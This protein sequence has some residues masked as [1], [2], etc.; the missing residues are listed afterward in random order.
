MKI[1]VEKIVLIAFF[2]LMFSL[3]PGTLFDNVIDHD[4]PY[5]Y[6]ASDAF[7]HQVRAEWVKDQGNYVLE[8]PHI[9]AGFTDVVGYYMPGAFHIAAMFSHLSGLESYDAIYFVVFFAAIMASLGMYMA[10][11]VYSKHV[12]LLSLPITTLT[13]VQNFYIGII[14]GQW[15]FIFGSFFLVGAF[16]SL[17]RLKLKNSVWLVALFISA[18]ALTHT[19]E[20]VFV[21][22]L[23][24]VAFLLSLLKK[25]MREIKTL[26]AA[27]IISGVV[28]IY[29]LI[30]FSY[31]WG[32]QFGYRF[33]VE[34]I[35]QGF[36]NVRLLQDFPTWI[37]QQ[38]CP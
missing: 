18:I 9:V 2:A 5:G 30:I 3:G 33:Y 24:G 1:D 25:D 8:A 15:P 16:W 27:G 4:F 37:S 11:R 12:A 13:F 31:T 29:Y 19:S 26:I 28:S 17:M 20:L 10:I 34:H 7:Q 21:V 38:A 23:V 35:N 14:L 32:L 6:A 36:P 22:G